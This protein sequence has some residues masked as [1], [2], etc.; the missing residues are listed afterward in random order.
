M[1]FCTEPVAHWPASLADQWALGIFFVPDSSVI[2]DKFPRLC[3]HWYW[4]QNSDLHLVWLV[5]Y[6]LILRHFLWP[7]QQPLLQSEQLPPWQFKQHRAE[8]A[9]DTDLKE[10]NKAER[11]WKVQGCLLRKNTS[12]SEG[13]RWNQVCQGKRVE[14]SLESLL[15][16]L[17]I[18]FASVY[19][20]DE[21]KWAFTERHIVV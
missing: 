13:T 17:I 4:D 7:S 15:T 6:R 9:V 18:S 19:V 20:S 2:T 12:S 16:D 10:K 8:H 11:H 3:L 1:R 21:H 5:F 14:D